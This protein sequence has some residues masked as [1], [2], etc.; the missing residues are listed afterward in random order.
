MRYLQTSNTRPDGTRDSFQTI[1]LES[2][3]APMPHHKLGLFWTATGYGSRIPTT[4]MV[5][6]NGKWRRVYCRVYSNIGT[7]YIGKITDGLIIQ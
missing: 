7:C 4:E 5:K 3:D 1:A 2:K 6:F